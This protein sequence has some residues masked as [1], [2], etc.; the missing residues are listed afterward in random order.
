MKGEVHFIDSYRAHTYTCCLRPEVTSELSKRMS[1]GEHWW[2]Y[3][4]AFLGRMVAPVCAIL[5]HLVAAGLVNTFRVFGSLSVEW[6]GKDGKHPRCPP[7]GNTPKGNKD[8]VGAVFPP[9]YV[10]ALRDAGMSQLHAGNMVWALEST[11]LSAVSTSPQPAHSCFF[12]LILHL[13]RPTLQ[14]ELP[15]TLPGALPSQP[16]PAAPFL[17]E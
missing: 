2:P 13:S 12:D 15:L 3:V 1:L 9:L 7:K 4:A 11:E 16:E 14:L 10:T 8:M 5:F 17:S 6:P